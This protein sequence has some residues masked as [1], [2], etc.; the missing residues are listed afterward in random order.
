MPHQLP[1]RL[2][3]ILSLAIGI[4]ATSLATASDDP[5]S[6]V[7]PVADAATLHIGKTAIGNDKMRA[8]CLGT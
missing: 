1:R 2:T 3:T 8:G 7:T 6:D 4:L 5:P